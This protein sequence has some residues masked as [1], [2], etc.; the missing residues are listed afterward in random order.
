MLSK[1]L[2]WYPLFASK[3]ELEQQF[4]GKATAVCNSLYGEFLLVKQSDSV[5]AFSNRCPHQNKPLDNCRVENNAIVC[6]FHQY[7]FS[8]VDGKGMGLYLEKYPLE[9]RVSGVYIGIEKW[10]LF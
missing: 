2:K 6:P 8:C 7:A 4:Y 9:F 3:E 5:L 1:K 10:Q